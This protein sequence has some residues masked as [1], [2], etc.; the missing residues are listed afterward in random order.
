MRK[1]GRERVDIR[2]Q[3]F[4]RDKITMDGFRHQR[5]YSSVETINWEC[6]RVQ[7]NQEWV[8]EFSMVSALDYDIDVPCVVQW[9]TAVVLCAHQPKQRL[10]ER[11]RHPRNIHQGD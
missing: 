8:S 11:W 2:R 6:A 10:A 3:S 4:T 7:A 5:R 9:W 1:F